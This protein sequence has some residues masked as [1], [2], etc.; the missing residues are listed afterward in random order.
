MRSPKRSTGARGGGGIFVQIVWENRYKNDIGNT[1][2]ASVDGVDFRV[3]GKKL[4]NGKPDKS[5]YSYTF[6]FPGLRYLIALG[7]RNSDIV[8]VAGPI[9]RMCG[10][11]D[12]MK[13]Q[14][15][16]EADDGYIAESPAVCVCPGGIDTRADQERMHG[17]L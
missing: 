4:A 10:I 15:K 14:D 16:V 5:Y 13:Q 11:M 1:C 8:Y 6:R 17:R 3:K 2:L 7:I 9:F 12:E